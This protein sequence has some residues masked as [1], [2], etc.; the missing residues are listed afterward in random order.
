M[1]VGRLQRAAVCR[2]ERWRDEAVLDTCVVRVRRGSRWFA[3]WRLGG[4]RERS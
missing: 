1:M 2:A 4:D 3:F